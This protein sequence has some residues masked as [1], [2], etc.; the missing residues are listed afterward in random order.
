MYASP[1]K[2]RYLGIDIIQVR[3]DKQEEVFAGTSTL[4]NRYKSF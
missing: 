4:Y 1:D 3:Y 2:N